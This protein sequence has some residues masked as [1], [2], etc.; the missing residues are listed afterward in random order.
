MST[1]VVRCRMSLFR[2]GVSCRRNE[3]GMLL[4]YW[5]YLNVGTAERLE[6]AP[7]FIPNTYIRHPSKCA[8]LPS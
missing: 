8:I 3:D 4:R 7:S 6:P 2:L 1:A 5:S